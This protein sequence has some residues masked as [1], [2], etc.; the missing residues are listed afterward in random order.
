MGSRL[1]SLIV[2]KLNMYISPNTY[3]Y[4]HTIFAFIFGDLNRSLKQST[5]EHLLQMNID[6]G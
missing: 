6:A 2:L 4:V 1:F 5:V 3:T